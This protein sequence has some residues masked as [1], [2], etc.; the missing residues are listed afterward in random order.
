MWYTVG[1]RTFNDKYRQ[2]RISGK[3]G[4]WEEEHVV[5]CTQSIDRGQTEIDQV[6]TASG[7]PNNCS[8]GYRTNQSS[9][10][11]YPVPSTCHRKGKRREDID[12]TTGL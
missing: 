3:V 1:L 5:C 12:L 7:F 11:K 10:S 4:V 6:V 8:N 9:T 2:M